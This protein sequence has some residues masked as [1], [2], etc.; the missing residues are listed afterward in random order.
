MHTVYITLTVVCLFLLE[1]STELG[2]PCDTNRP[3]PNGE[4]C[5][6]NL[7]IV[8]KRRIAPAFSKTCQ[9]YLTKGQSCGTFFSNCGCTP[10][11]QCVP[12]TTQSS[13]DQPIRRKIVKGSGGGYTCV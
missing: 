3:C 1:T 4:C 12:T 13:P 5:E 11:L 10:G 9:P 8:S 2:A 6:T 7:M